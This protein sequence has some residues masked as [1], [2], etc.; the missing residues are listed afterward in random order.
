MVVIGSTISP[1]TGDNPIRAA[2]GRN[3]IIAVGRLTIR[4]QQIAVRRVQIA[5]VIAQNNVVARTSSD[6]IY[7]T[8]TNDLVAAR[9]GGDDISTVADDLG[10]RTT[11]RHHDALIGVARDEVAVR[12]GAT[13]RVVGASQNHTDLVWRRR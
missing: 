6:A 11:D 10:R 5:A 4:G 1:T 3:N 12:A 13:D 8:P 2:F 9:P 7:K